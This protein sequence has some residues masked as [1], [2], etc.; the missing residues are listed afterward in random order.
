MDDENYRFAIT[1]LGGPMA[2]NDRIR[3]LV[4]L[5]EKGRWF[6]PQVDNF[7][8]PDGRVRNATEEFVTEELLAFPV[9]THDDMLDT[10]S[11]ILDPDFKAVFPA[12]TSP[13]LGRPETGVTQTS[14]GWR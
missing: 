13:L 9:S 1:P 12:A 5:F 14:T 10:K 7:V 4:P 6:L 3:R 11:R 2:K 8:D